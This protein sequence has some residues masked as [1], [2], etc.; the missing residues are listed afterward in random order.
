M[1]YRL[2]N[3]APDGRYRL[4]KAIIA[5]PHRTVVLVRVRLEIADESLRDKLR[6]YAV[7][8]P[9]LGGVGAG[10]SGY[11]CEKAQARLLHAERGGVHLIM[12]CT[13]GFSKRSAGFVGTSDGWQ[14]LH[15]G[16]FQMDW[17]PRPCVLSFGWLAS[18]TRTAPSHKTPGPMAA[19]IGEVSNS[20]RWPLPCCWPGACSRRMHWRAW[21]RGT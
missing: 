3:S 11:R 2:T 10:N 20:M 18:R 16:N 9:R 14:D 19:L 17:R 5:D 8:A 12:A 4:I 1:L 15:K 7:V 6:I 21:T 13:G